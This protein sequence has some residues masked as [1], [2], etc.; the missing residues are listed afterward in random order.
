MKIIKC[1]GY[2]VYEVKICQNLQQ[3][4]VKIYMYSDTFNGM[5]LWKICATLQWHGPLN[6]TLTGNFNWGPISGNDIV[7]NVASYQ[8]CTYPI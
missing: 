5:N 4:K 8:L 7:S 2:F 3:R 6:V 1:S